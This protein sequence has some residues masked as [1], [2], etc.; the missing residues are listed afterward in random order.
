MRV[1]AQGKLREM[2][3]L[4]RPRRWNENERGGG[5]FYKSVRQLK[6]PQR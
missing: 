3:A 6:G 5:P 2:G 4:R 1:A